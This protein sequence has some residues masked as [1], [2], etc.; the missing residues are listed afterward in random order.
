M[1]E[2]PEGKKNYLL[3][4]C[5]S[6]DCAA[7]NWQTKD[8]TM[9]KGRWYHKNTVAKHRTEDLTLVATQVLPPAHDRV[10]ENPPVAEHRLPKVLAVVRNEDE[11]MENG[12]G[13]AA[14]RRRLIFL[15]CT[16]VS[17]LHLACALSRDASNRVLKVLGLIIAMV[18]ASDTKHMYKIPEDVRTAVKHLSIEPV[19]NRSICCPKC[20]RAYSFEELP[21]TCLARETGGS[22]PCNTPLWV[23]RQTRG[24]PKIVPRRLY[25]TQDFHSWLAYFLSRPGMEELLRKSHLHRPNPER[26]SSIWDSPAWQSLGSYTSE[27]NNL[28][29]S[30]YIDWFNPFQNKIA[31]KSASCGAII[32][33]CLN[34]PYEMWHLEENTYFAGITPPPKEPTVTTIT[35][36]SDPVVDQFQEM[37]HGKMVPTQNHPDGDFYRAAAAP[38]ASPIIF[39]PFCK[40][41]RSEI[42]RLDYANFQPRI[43]SEVRRW[44]KAWLVAQTQAARKA[45]FAQHGCR[46]SSVN[47][48]LTYRDPVK[49]TVIGMMHN[50]LQGVLQHHCR[51]KWGIGS[52]ASKTGSTSAFDMASSSDSD[53]DADVEM[54]DIDGST[55][56][57]K[58]EDLYQD[59]CIQNDMP[60]SLIRRA[61]SFF[62]IPESDDNAAEPCE[63]YESEEEEDD[64]ELDEDA[65]YASEK[66]SRIVF[67]S[68]AMAIIH[69]GLAGVVIPA[70]IDRPPVNLGDKMHG[71]LKADNWFVL[72]TIFFPLIIPELWW[73]PSSSRKDLKLLDNFHDLMGATNIVCSYTAS[74]GEADEYD[75]F[76]VRYLQ[77]SRSLFPG[78]TTRPNHHYAMHNG[79]QMKW[80][81]LLPKLSEFMYESH[82][83]SLQK[84]KTNN[85]M[86]ELD[87]TMLCQS[88]V[89]EAMRIL[90]PR[91]P[92]SMNPQ[93]PQQLSPAQETAYNGSG[94]V[95]D[96]LTYELI[97]DYWN[98][99]HSPPYIRAA[100]LTYDLLD[101]GINVFPSRAVQLTSFMHKTRLFCTFKN[102]PGNS[103]ISFRHPLTGRKDMGFIRAIWS[104]VLQG[105]SRTFVVV[106]PHTDVSPTDAAKTPYSTHP[107]FACLVRYSEPLH[108]Q[109]QLIVEPRHIISHVA[110]Y[111]RRQ[112]TFGIK[113]AITIFVDSL[114]RNR[115]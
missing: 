57:A 66:P 14:A 25:S 33:V 43:G 46:W 51:L 104:Q 3:C 28:V 70:W 78:L 37:W 23:E 86:W 75:E 6:H 84:I 67:D 91:E 26:M 102:H 107:R 13:L 22:R 19:I 17:W 56:E 82:N 5:R 39:V 35:A 95:L 18:A 83:G 100:E 64:D 98:H 114:H 53:A 112:G 44:S 60:T 99:T 38:V 9:K 47:N 94:V 72:F 48:K 10:A 109:P 97:L 87:L 71:K 41:Q 96:T 73:G 16:L 34:L 111:R 61:S 110:Y 92:V 29:F 115:D 81:G 32:A 8:G 15:A 20:Y 74:P 101:A 69:A 50:W 77:S 108:P 79:E 42:D 58:L 54:M 62:F 88:P 11:I 113:E 65:I 12:I 7:Q 89:V 40:L 27:P 52:D 90:S 80:W 36:L 106:Q 85:H 21:Q 4:K 45:I 55:I 1:E 59:S 68:D 24:G 63:G 76:Y 103:S 31:G 30:F 49:H 93:S 2:H 105:Q